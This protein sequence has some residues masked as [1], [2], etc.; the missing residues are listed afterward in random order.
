MARVMRRLLLAVALVLA[1][2]GAAPR[3]SPPLAP[4]AT[5]DSP[6]AT[7]APPLVIIAPPP[8]APVAT[9]PPVPLRTPFHPPPPVLKTP[10]PLPRP[11]PTP[12]PVPLAYNVSA[13]QSLINGDRARAGRGPLAWSGCLAAEAQHVAA[14]EA[15]AGALSEYGS[16]LSA[17]LACHLG[18]GAGEN[19]G[20]LGAGINDAIINAW[21]LRSP[22][23]LANILGPYHYVG[24]AWVVARNGTAW[25]AVEFS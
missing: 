17:D 16:D 10:L 6:T 19:S 11:R 25:I 20:W 21:F 23:H 22:P 5:P 4:A 9:I 24:T 15:A 13:Q 12:G 14:R 8:G 1:A 3:A 2:C 18:G 7:L